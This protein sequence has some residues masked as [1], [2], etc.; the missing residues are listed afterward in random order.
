MKNKKMRFFRINC[1]KSTQGVPG[2][3]YFSAGAKHPPKT[4]KILTFPD[5]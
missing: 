1:K 5:R 3:A 4:W 2:R